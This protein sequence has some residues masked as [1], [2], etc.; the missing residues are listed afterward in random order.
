MKQALLDS[1]SQD[2]TMKTLHLCL[3]WKN[4]VNLMNSPVMQI[5]ELV[6]AAIINFYLWVQIQIITVNTV[7]NS[8]NDTEPSLALHLS[9]F[10]SIDK[11]E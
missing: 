11:L 6:T 7:G 5:T 3:R 9:Q 10:P 4:Q 8:N 2:L 1:D